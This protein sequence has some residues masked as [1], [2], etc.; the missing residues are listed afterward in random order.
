MKILWVS[1]FVV[2]GFIIVFEVY[3]IRASAQGKNQPYTIIKIA[4]GYQIRLYPSSTMAIISSSSKT[5]KD[6]GRNGFGILA[7][8][9]FGSNK[10][11]QKIEMTAPVYMEVSDS[12]SSMSFV[13]PKN[14]T[15]NTAPIPNNSDVKLK[16]VPEIL[17]AVIEF[18]GFS[19]DSKIKDNQEKLKKF[20]DRDLI[21]YFG[22]FQYLGYNPPYQLFCRRNEV[23]V[24]VKLN[25]FDFI[26]K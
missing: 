16:T 10:S 7:K 17:V 2:V 9:I 19:N 24:R 5:Y 8:Y 15:Q 14:I 20:L 12:S 23:I 11:N 18:D 25:E 13:M 26:T 3:T 4:D 1:L 22:N 21:Q 6:L